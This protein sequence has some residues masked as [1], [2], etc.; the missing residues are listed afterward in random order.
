MSIVTLS[1]DSIVSPNN[2]DYLIN[3]YPDKILNAIKL[4][5]RNFPVV[6][7]FSYSRTACISNHIALQFMFRSIIQKDKFTNI[8]M[9]CIYLTDFKLLFILY[10]AMDGIYFLLN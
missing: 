4:D 9:L 8:Y 6:S 3:T 1:H 5:E 10:S 7:P 2:F